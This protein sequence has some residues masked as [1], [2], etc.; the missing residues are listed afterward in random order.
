MVDVP[1]VF[2]VAVLP[3]IVATEVLLDV[4]VVLD[5][6]TSVLVTAPLVICCLTT[7]NAFVPPT[8]IVAEVGDTSSE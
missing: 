6:T 3:D 8:L 2:P 4:K 7:V 1:G 5:V